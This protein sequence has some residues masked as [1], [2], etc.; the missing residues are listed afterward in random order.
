MNTQQQHRVA[1]HTAEI[2]HLK[3]GNYLV[4]CPHGCR[5]GSTEIQPT[6]EGA[7]KRVRLHR[8]ATGLHQDQREA[9]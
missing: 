2:L 9:K 8:L 1:P 4:A 3:S 6:R 7:E 5:L